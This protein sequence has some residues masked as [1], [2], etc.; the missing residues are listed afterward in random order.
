MNIVVLAGGLSPERDVS[1]CSGIEVR[2]ALRHKGH[3]AVMI[4]VYL[5]IEQETGDLDAVFDWDIAYPG[6]GGIGHEAPDLE[7]I[8]LMRRDQSPALIGPRVLAMCRRAD[9]VFLALHGAIGE[10]GKLQAALD[11]YGIRYT[12]SGALGSAIAMDKSMSKQLFVNSRLLTP[13]A[14][15]IRRGD[16]ID[17]ATI[18]YPCMVKPCSG[19]SSVGATPVNEIL[20]L[21]A[22]ISLAF[23]YEDKILIEDFIKGREF[24][25]AV[26]GQQA[27]PVIEICPKGEF[28]DYKHKYQ[29][30][31]CQEICPARLDPDTAG[32]M[33]EIALQ[34][35]QALELA[36]FARMDFILA[37]SGEIYILEANT[38]PGMTKASLLPKEAAAAGIS[39]AEM[40]QRIVDYSLQKY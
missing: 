5:G 24:S 12:G 18:R 30:D 38:V 7:E 10:N 2:N 6:S 34:A 3:R 26:L 36:V 9:V 11:I 23:H 8:R 17:P 39:Y 14:R 21:D 4:D 32:R 19:G 1:L 28:F 25:V 33:Q 16:L 22:A 15:L 13:P 29:S 27:L 40:C 35:Y 31:I 37:D 20:A